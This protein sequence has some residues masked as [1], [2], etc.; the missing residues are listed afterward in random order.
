MRLAFFS[1]PIPSDGE[2]E[3]E[4]NRFLASHRVASVDR[5]VVQMGSV[6]CWAL[7]VTYLPAVPTTK[8]GKR[9]KIDYKEVLSPTDF[10]VFARLRALRKEWA[11]QEGV[12]AY[13]LFTNEQLAAMVTSKARSRADLEKLPGVGPARI[14]KYAKP[15]LEVLLAASDQQSETS[16]A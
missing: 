14:A 13:A 15:F 4:V 3:A 16:H 1:V 11:E 7:C 9:G 12:P 5:Q 6:A 2:A 8:V 10:T